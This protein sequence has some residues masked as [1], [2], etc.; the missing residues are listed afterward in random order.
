MANNLNSS[1]LRNLTL[2]ESEDLPYEVEAYAM[3]KHPELVLKG[4][5]ACANNYLAQN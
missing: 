5:D 1:D 2:Y 4:L 3:E